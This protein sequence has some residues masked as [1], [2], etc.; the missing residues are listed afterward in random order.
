[1]LFLG[2]RD[3]A[4]VAGQVQLGREIG[5]R[6]VQRDGLAEPLARSACQPSAGRSQSSSER[7]RWPAPP[8]CIRRPLLH[9]A[10]D[11]V[12]VE[13]HFVRIAVPVITSRTGLPPD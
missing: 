1:M 4:E 7:P 3:V 8:V 5:G 6:V 10:R 12:N 11:G 9:V 2:G 13:L